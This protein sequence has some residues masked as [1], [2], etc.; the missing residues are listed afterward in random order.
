MVLIG[1]PSLEG[2]V[3]VPNVYCDYE[4]GGYLFIRHL[5]ELGHRNFLFQAGDDFQNHPRWSGALRAFYTGAG[6]TVFNGKWTEASIP[7]SRDLISISQPFVRA[8]AAT[9]DRPK[10]LPPVCELREASGR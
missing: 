5:L 4:E 2:P 3:G 1:S 8:R 7:E 6:R 9:I 10:P